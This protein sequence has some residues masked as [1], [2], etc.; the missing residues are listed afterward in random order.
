MK[1]AV[2][3]VEEVEP[4]RLPNRLVR[5][6]FSGANGLS[7]ACS[8][9]TVDVDPQDDAHPRVPHVHAAMEEIIV[10]ARGE[11]ALWVEGEWTRVS[12]GD[13]W[14]VPMG[15]R[16]ATVNPGPGVLRLYCFFSSARPEADYREIPDR[17]LS[18]WRS[19]WGPRG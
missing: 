10:V 12:E 3:T 13:A 9:R 6:V 5:E 14:I 11:G 2:R 15:E 1:A 16:H 7:A 19:L 18:G 17:P 4:F 8:F